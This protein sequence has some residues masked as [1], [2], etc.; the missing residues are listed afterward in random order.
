M[1]VDEKFV[2]NEVLEEMLKSLLLIV[3]VVSKMLVRPNSGK[4]ASQSSILLPG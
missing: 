3:K 1:F 2:E 4:K